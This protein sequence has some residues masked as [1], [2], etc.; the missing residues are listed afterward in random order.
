MH[1]SFIQHTTWCI[2]QYV[3]I[4]ILCATVAFITDM[5]GTY[6][7]G[8]I[9]NFRTSYVYIAVIQNFSQV[10]ALYCLVLFYVATEEALAPM[11]PLWKFAAVKAVVFMTFWQSVAVAI[12]ANLAI[13][14]C[15]ATYS[16]D[17][18]SAG[19]QDFA[20]CFEM[21][22]VAISHLW[23][24]PHMEFLDDISQEQADRESRPSVWTTDTDGPQHLESVL[25]AGGHGDGY[26][27]L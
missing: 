14:H 6:G 15:T 5:Q 11:R 19:L 21:L 2:L 27:K 9:T 22:V 18:V 12:L 4:K 26:H 8:Q 7:G 13:I 16:T 10:W 20:I 25:A 3:P 23:I 1:I 24:F 17:D